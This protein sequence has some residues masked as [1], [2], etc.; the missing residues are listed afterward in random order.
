MSSKNYAYCVFFFFCLFSQSAFSNSLENERMRFS[1][2]SISDGLSQST[3][4]SIKQDKTGFLWVATADGLNRYDGYTFSVYKHNKTDENSIQSDLIRHIYFDKDNRLWLGTGTGLSFYDRENNKFLNYPLNTQVNYIYQHTPE[5]LYVATNAGAFKFDN[6]TKSFHPIV[7]GGGNLAQIQI[8]INYNNLLL[9]GGDN[10]LFMSPLD[11]E[12]FVPFSKEL[13]GKN[14]I[15][16]LPYDRGLWVATEGDGLYHFDN[17]GRMTQYKHAEN[18]PQTISSNYVRSLCLDMQERLWVGTFNGL[19]ILNETTGHFDRYYNNEI[20][21]ETIA[22]NSVR[23]LYLDNQGAMWIGTFYGGLNYYHPLRNR[24]G[25]LNHIPYTNSLNDNVVSCITEGK[26]NELW[27]GTNDNGINVYDIHTQ[28]FTYY[29]ANDSRKLITSNNV[30][31]ILTDG[32]NVYI[33]THGGGLSHLQRK[34]G[35]ITIYTTANSEL[36]GNNIYALSKTPDGNIW[37]GTL[38]GLMIFNPDNHT[39]TQFFQDKAQQKL[40]A[41]QIYALSLDS[42]NRLWIGTDN[43]VFCYSFNGKKLDHFSSSGKQGDLSDA[44]INCIYE[45]NKKRIWIGTR[46]GLN[47]FDENSRKFTAYHTEDGLPNNTVFGILQDSFGRLWIS[48]NKGLTCFISETEKFRTYQLI[49]GIQSDQ[50]NNYAYCKTASGVMFFG[51]INGIT[52]FIPEQLGDNPFTPRTILSQLTLFNQRVL[53][54][55]DTK[56]LKKDISETDE[57]V[58]R[59]NQS[60]FSLTFTVPNYLSAKHNTFAYKLTPFESDWNYTSD[61]RTV[62]YANLPHGKYVFQVKAANSDGKWNNVPTTLNIRVLPYWWQTIFARLIFLLLTGGIIYFILKFFRHRAQLQSQLAVERLE[63][64]K[65]E[66]I[67]QMK[68]RFFIN[69][70]HE[71]RTPLTLILSPLQEIISHITDKWTRDQLKLVLRNTNK[72]LYLVNQLMDYRRAEL[73][74]FEL[75]VTEQDPAPQIEESMKMFERAAKQKKVDFILENDL[76]DQIV[77]HD[78]Y[79]LGLIL[80]NLLSNAFKF[81]PEG[82]KI[83]IGLSLKQD[84]FI[85]QVHDTGCGMSE[86]HLKRIFERFYQ[87]NMENIGT[88]IGLSLV[89]RLVDL[90]HGKVTVESTPG[91]GSDFYIYLPQDAGLYSPQ[92]RSGEGQGLLPQ[93]NI[94]EGIIDL[95]QITEEKKENIDVDE[96]KPLLLIVEDDAD[97]REY[98]SENFKAIANI[99]T[100]GDGEEALKIIKEKDVDI[101]ISDLMLPVMDGIRMCKAI[102][103][104]I[105]TCHIPIILLTAK[106]TQQDQLEGLSAGADDYVAKPFHLSILKTKVQNML[107]AK[108]RTLEH[109]SNTLEIDPEKVT[110]N[111]MDKELLEKAKNIV[112]KQLDN[113]EF[114]VDDFCK[115]MGMSRSNLHLKLKAVTGES[116]IDFIRKIRFSHACQLLKDGRY[117]IA[118]I[119]TIVGFNTPSYFT[120]SFKK[121]FGVL[122]TEYVK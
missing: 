92:E 59:P 54:G 18:N 7:T 86:E 49:D 108:R 111:E 44:H 36:C 19:N 4:F 25:R 119:S 8:I 33:G 63:K 14:I 15:D 56:L 11:E 66:E 80:N 82:G 75:K 10:G 53:P 40:S 101:I 39:F 79:Y 99:E 1:S 38:D 95:M 57:L 34:T 117:S 50:F 106:T 122:P 98:L 2:L 78:P 24:F 112:E 84:H 55:D 58:F 68:L 96:T 121:Y 47:L 115:E 27:I 20:E 35:K 13:L 70:S 51:G 110:F 46:S 26:P 22:Q 3:V 107:K 43:G 91:K 6:K 5:L 73:G 97:V 109:Y 42:R 32:D 48:T 94:P 76:H 116:T 81:T 105:R 77:L 17:S 67:N 65:M 72:L 93:N 114:S 83:N 120:T 71:F 52:Y 87:V 102:K 100:A 28:R 45:D 9:I 31:A 113:S 41:K 104:N 62:S 103:Q 37:I 118:E 12:H 29:T 88:G 74:V 16:L 89:K 69:I 61:I 60:S 23:S 85:L 21:K 90:H 64:D 30:K